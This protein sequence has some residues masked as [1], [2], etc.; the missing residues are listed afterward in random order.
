[1]MRRS[2]TRRTERHS[3]ELPLARLTAVFAIVVAMAACSDTTTVPAPEPAPA[4]AP[5]PDPDP[6]PQPEPEPAPA[7]D[8]LESLPAEVLATREALLAAARTGDWGAL[9]ALIPTDTPFTSNFGGDT[10]HIAYYRAVEID[11]FAE[12]EALLEGPFAPLS[13]NGIVVW[14]ELYAR[15]PFAF[16]AD[17]RDDLAA[18]YG[19]DRLAEWERAGDYLG[20]R[21]GITEGGEWIFL[22]AGD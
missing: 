4:P 8:P 3:T 19:T 20:W 16:G 21:L 15:V 10:E 2:V 6:A 1:M 14:P 18:R 9:G 11:L 22:V 13:S 17:E 7:P 5:A 12:I